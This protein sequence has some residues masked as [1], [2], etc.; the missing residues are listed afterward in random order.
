MKSLQKKMYEVSVKAHY[1]IKELTL[2]NN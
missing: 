1:W 2:N